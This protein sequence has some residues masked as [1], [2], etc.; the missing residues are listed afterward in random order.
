MYAASKGYPD[1]CSF[2]AVLEQF[3][4]EAHQEDLYQLCNQECMLTVAHAIDDIEELTLHERHQFCTAP[5][6]TN[7]PAVF[8]AFIDMANMCA[9]HPRH[10]IQVL[11]LPTH[12]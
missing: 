1:Q 10:R 8:D 5:V 3:V 6:D 4:M 11:L 12:S 9:S 2:A 7:K